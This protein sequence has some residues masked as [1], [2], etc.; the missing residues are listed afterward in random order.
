MMKDLEKRAN[1]SCGKVGYLG[2]TKGF[3]EG[4]LIAFQKDQ[5]SHGVQDTEKEAER[6]KRRY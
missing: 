3:G 6:K 1:M 2:V 5:A 4:E